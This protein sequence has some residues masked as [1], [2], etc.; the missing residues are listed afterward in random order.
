MKKD[1]LL[2]LASD[3]R[4]FERYIFVNKLPRKDVIFIFHPR[5]LI[6]RTIQSSRVVRTEGYLD[7]KNQ[8][9]ENDLLRCMI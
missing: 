7:N 1:P 4:D 5:Q 9:L 3:R 2:I 8:I 6:G